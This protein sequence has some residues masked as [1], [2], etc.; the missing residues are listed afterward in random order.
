MA[1][2][3]VIAPEADTA[4]V[5]VD[6]LRKSSFVECCEI[7]EPVNGADSCAGREQVTLPELDSVDTVVYF[8]SWL[9]HHRRTPDLAKARALFDQ[10]ARARIKKLILL[11]STAVYGASPHNP[12]LLS[13]SYPVPRDG[14]NLIASEWRELEALARQRLALERNV[15]LTILRPATVLSHVRAD[16]VSQLLSGR[17]AI[18]LPGHDP[19]LQLLHPDDVV[20]AIGCAIQK[21]EGGV[22]NV[23]PDGAIPLRVALRWA[24][25]KRIPVPRI[26]QRLVRLG[27]ARVGLA[28]P[29][30]QLEY[31]RYSWTA[32]NKK[33]KRELGFKPRFSSAEALRAFIRERSQAPVESGDGSKLDFDDFGLD[34]EY[35][36]AY[37]RTL[38]NFLSRYYWRIEMSGADH[39]PRSG[40]AVLA[41][42]HRGFMPFD[43]VMALH[44]IVQATGRFPRFLIHPTLIKFP[45]QFNFMTKLGG[46]IACQENADYVLQHDELL[47]VFPEGIQ[48]AFTLYREAYR[49]GD[50]FRDDF[51]RMALRNH[52]AIVPFVTVGSAEIFPILKRIRWRWWKRY[53]E[54]PF[55][56][57]TLTFP[58]LPLPLPSKWHTQFLPPLHVERQYPPETANDAATV[59]AISQTVRCQMQEAIDSMLKRRKSIFFGS[60]FKAEVS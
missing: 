6:R 18:T 4:Q 32:S 34:K 3:A 53:T 59:R 48:G 43:G 13:E 47:G 11:S 24:G 9:A 33:S 28:H 44:G 49:V 19:S 52:S 38:F 40:R 51:V 21:A 50:L 8:P 5:V 12:G 41:G 20:N 58:L 23:A 37:G 45:F 56:P 25:S 2:V 27:L 42:I 39:I 36:A 22:F 7:T 29:A 14:R 17:V 55:F 54:W 16:Y 60:L 26:L 10:C 15:E 1:R 46:I 31:V 30:D 35:I 57:L